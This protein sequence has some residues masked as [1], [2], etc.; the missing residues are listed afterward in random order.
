M[1]SYTP[2][3][4]CYIH[5]CGVQY[6]T[7]NGFYENPVDI[8]V[9]GREQQSSTQNLGERI[10]L[11]TGIRGFAETCTLDRIPLHRNLQEATADAMVIN[12]LYAVCGSGIAIVCGSSILDPSATCT[13]C[14]LVKDDNQEVAAQVR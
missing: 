5:S 9:K 10:F 3:L 14:L 13:Y 2:I 8:V 12:L 4:Y 11:V 7:Q 6:E 1:K